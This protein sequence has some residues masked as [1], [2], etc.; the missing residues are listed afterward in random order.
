[1]SPRIPQIEAGYEVV[2]Q[3]PDE[4]IDCRAWGHERGHQDHADWDGDKGQWVLHMVCPRCGVPYKVRLTASGYLVPGQRV[5]N[6]QYPKDYL[7]TEADLRSKEGRAAV[8]LEWMRRQL[9]NRSRSNVTQ[10]RRRKGA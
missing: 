9:T 6:Y 8:R 4:Y 2:H 10:L 1:M 5:S 3:L 7:V